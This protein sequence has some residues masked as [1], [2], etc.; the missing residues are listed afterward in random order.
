MVD[1]VSSFYWGHSFLACVA[2]VS[3]ILLFVS[4]VGPRFAAS[5]SA[6]LVVGFVVAI[7]GVTGDHLDV[8]F[9]LFMEL[10]VEG[11]VI[12]TSTPGCFDVMLL[13]LNMF[14][15][16]INDGSN[17]YAIILMPNV[18]V[19]KAKRGCI[20]CSDTRNGSAK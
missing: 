18:S 4:I 9:D 17:A 10:E 19:H 11:C 1:A 8:T 15:S 20:R 13:R 12:V 16:A 2:S 14:R 5:L 7:V 6:L 3:F